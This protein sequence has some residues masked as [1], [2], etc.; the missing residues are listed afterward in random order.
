MSTTACAD[1]C[2]L[3]RRWRCV[4]EG[5]R[6]LVQS[7][8]EAGFTVM[9]IWG[10]GIWEPRAF[11]DACDEF[12]VLLYADLQIAAKQNYSLGGR[13][14][15]VVVPAELEYQ[16][17]RL[18]HHAS[19]ALWDGCNGAPCQN[20]VHVEQVA[21]ASHLSGCVSC[22]VPARDSGVPW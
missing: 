7:A 21:A 17:K 12:G 9:R 5:H 15:R 11:F 19:I 22:R 8:A 16:I 2:P 14:Y 3:S 13:N 20:S 1:D 4:S 6:R 18:S 10:G